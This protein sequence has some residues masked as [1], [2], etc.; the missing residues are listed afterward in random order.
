MN[1][2]Q[3]LTRYSVITYHSFCLHSLE[4]PESTMSERRSLCSFIDNWHCRM[5]IFCVLH[6]PDGKRIDVTIYFA[7]YLLKLSHTWFLHPLDLYCQ[8]GLKCAGVKW[9][10]ISH[11]ALNDLI[12]GNTCWFFPHWMGIEGIALVT[13]QQSANAEWDD[14]NVHPR[15]INNAVVGPLVKINMKFLF[16]LSFV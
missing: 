3:Q 11:D 16:A 2:H 5:G 8:R 9:K 15:Y 14:K 7:F 6:S 10:F 1:H 13:S 12:I 4:H